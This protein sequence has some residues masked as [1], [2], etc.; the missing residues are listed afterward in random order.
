MSERAFAAA[1]L[2]FFPSLSATLNHIFAVD[3]FYYDALS[4][5]GRGLAVF[6]HTQIDAP[7][8]LAVR[9]AEADARLISFCNTLT[10]ALLLHL[11]QHQIHHRGQAHIQLQTAGLAPP[12]LEAFHLEFERA[13]SAQSAAP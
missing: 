1:W 3:L 2:R 12:Q 4:M 8:T 13:E 6:D 7:Q 5:A 10:P 9:H 11:F